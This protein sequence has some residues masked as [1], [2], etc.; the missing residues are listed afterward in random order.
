MI[1]TALP[2]RTPD[3]SAIATPTRADNYSSAIVLPLGSKETF[4][5][6]EGTYFTGITPTPG[7]GVIGHAAP[8]TFDQTKAYIYL[9]NNS[10]TVS[11][12]PQFLQLHNTAVSVGDTRVQF[13]LVLDSTNRFASGGS[14]LTVNNT[15]MPSAIATQAT[16]AKIGA[17]VLA[18]NT[19]A[20]RTIGNIVFRGT[21]DVVEDVY[22]IVF[23]GVG[24]GSTT[25]SRV[26]TVGDFSRTFAPIC[27]GPQQGLAIHQ[28]A[29]GQ[30]TGPTY[31]AIMGWVER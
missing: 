31:E 5:A 6:G 28:W 14:N 8:T 15:N 27:V 22:E 9:F 12:Y 16:T 4:L 2:S 1:A 10:S 20:S 17:V 3:S 25:G 26:A 7:T 13:T 29:T 11:L 18:T 30:S 23:A 21:I 24:G 19:A